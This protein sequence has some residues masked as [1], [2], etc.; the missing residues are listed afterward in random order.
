MGRPGRGGARGAGARARGLGHLVAPRPPWVRPSLGTHK[1]DGRPTTTGALGTSARRRNARPPSTSEAPPPSCARPLEP[2][3]PPLD[4]AQAALAQHPEEASQ[5]TGEGAAPTGAGGNR[6]FCYSSTSPSQQQSKQKSATACRPATNPARERGGAGGDH[7]QGNT[8]QCEQWSPM[9]CKIHAGFL[10]GVY[11][12][13][14]ALIC[15]GYYRLL[16]FY[17]FHLL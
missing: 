11:S 7:Q 9:Y 4:A 6:A 2:A 3:P 10:Q 1:S 14:V 12:E 16:Y 8:K 13:C 15:N 17:Y 5:A